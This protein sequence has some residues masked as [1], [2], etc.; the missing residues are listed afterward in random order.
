MEAPLKYKILFWIVLGML[1]TFFAE[2]TSGSYIYP[3]FTFDGVLF[4]YT[5]Y[6]LHTLV[7]AHIIFEY[8]KPRFY[9]LF[10][11][12]AIFGM[13]EAYITKVLWGAGWGETIITVGGIAVVETLVLV[14]FWHAFMSFV[15]PL[16]VGERLT[17]SSSVWNGLPEWLKKMPRNKAYL[18]LA[19]F[20]LILGI[21]QSVNTSVEDCLL[22][23]VLSSGAV[24]LVMFLWTKTKGKEYTMKELLPN[25]KE[26]S[27]LLVLLLAYYAITAPLLRTEQL[28]DLGP[29]MIIW[30][31]YAFLFVLLYLSLERS[32]AIELPK[33]KPPELNWKLVIGWILLFAAST[34]LSKLILGEVAIVLVIISWIIGISAGFASLIL[35]FKDAIIK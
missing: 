29:Q 33:L 5:L 7:L 24:A 28:P 13:Y 34:T 27:I 19:A 10:L 1:S 9:P 12:G 3:F 21:T 26:F 20:T 4:V 25:K 16:I 11:A 6:A 17:N 8:G 23:G 18:G 32:K 22:S 14:L 15:I 2:V 31:I 30:A 35:A